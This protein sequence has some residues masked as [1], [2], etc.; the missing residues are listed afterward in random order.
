MC[1]LWVTLVT[2]LKW[3]G[4]GAQSRNEELGRGL[5]PSSWSAA[6]GLNKLSNDG[7]TWEGYGCVMK[8][9][10]IEFINKFITE[11]MHKGL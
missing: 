8:R 3:A 7:E 11:R 6:K 2:G 5:H 9:K 4:C 10:L 1:L